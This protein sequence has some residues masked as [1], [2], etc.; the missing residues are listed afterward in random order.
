MTPLNSF[1]FVYKET[2]LENYLR[3]VNLPK[4][5][6]LNLSQTEDWLGKHPSQ[7]FVGRYFFCEWFKEHDFLKSI[8]RG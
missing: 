8:L 3:H 7:L 5:A 6:T 2:I 4:L 1:T